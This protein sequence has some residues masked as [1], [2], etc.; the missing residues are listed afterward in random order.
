VCSVHRANITTHELLNAT[1]YL[2]KKMM[3]KILE[4]H[5]YLK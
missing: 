5:K 3:K 4:M 2:R 1:R